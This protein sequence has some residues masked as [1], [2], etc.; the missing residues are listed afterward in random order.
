M[1]DLLIQDLDLLGMGG[2]DHWPIVA[3]EP[4]AHPDQPAPIERGIDVAFEKT[5][6]VL[7]AIETV[8]S[9]RQS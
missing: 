9:L 3:L 7:G 6:T 4:A 1:D 2:I 5:P 8:K